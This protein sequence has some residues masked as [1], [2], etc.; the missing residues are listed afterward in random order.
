MQF[1]NNKRESRL[2]VKGVDLEF[3]QPSQD[4]LELIVRNKNQRKE[5]SH[6]LKKN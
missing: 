5:E 1:H 6:K 3:I 2:C 4:V